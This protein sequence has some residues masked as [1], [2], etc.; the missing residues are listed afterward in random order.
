MNLFGDV[1]VVNEHDE[2]LLLQRA[3]NSDFMPGAYWIPG[4]HIEMGENP[5]LGAIRE[6]YEETTIAGDATYLETV[7]LPNSNGVSFR[8][9]CH[10][11]MPNVVIDNDES[12]SYVWVNLSEL[13]DYPLVGSA[14]ELVRLHELLDNIR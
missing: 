14:D 4:G 1:L 5:R 2:I 7:I 8:Y 12:A 13:D 3:L 10:V 11:A 9:G 6:L